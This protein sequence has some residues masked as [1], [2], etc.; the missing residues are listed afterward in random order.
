MV[1]DLI[2]WACYLVGLYYTGFMAS[3]L[4]IMAKPWVFPNDWSK[5]GRGSWAVI[6][7]ATDG[8]GWGYA[9]VLASG[10]Y[11]IVLIARNSEKLREKAQELISKSNVEV[12]TIAKDFSECNRDPI[13][14]FGDIQ[15]QI[16]DLDVSILVNNVGYAKL[17]QLHTVP[18][19]VVTTQLSLNIWPIV[20]MTHNLLPH[21]MRRK[22]PCAIINLSAVGG[23]VVPFSGASVYCGGK[24][25]DD[26]F[27][28]T[29]GEEIKMYEAAGK[30]NHIDV[31]SQRSA[32]VDT[33][34]TRNAFRAQPLC[35]T[36]IQNAEAGLR[37]LGR[38]NASHCHPK[39]WIFATLCKLTPLSLL[40]SS[41]RF[42]ISKQA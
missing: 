2:N 33:P 41:Q 14:F 38:V 6:T 17:G 11:N 5:Y 29:L 21:M 3:R 4:Y 40:N 27:S 18:I 20:Y 19:N 37:T 25:F 1:G 30:S 12:R 16:S 35:I 31:L 28:R 36:A 22:R 32:F 39:H 42:K 8:I 10:G 15:S 34:L 9:Q 23:S 24:A 26:Y 13:H 7:G